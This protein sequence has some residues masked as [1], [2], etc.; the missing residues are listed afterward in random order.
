MNVADELA[1]RNLI[2]RIAWETDTWKSVEV[3]LINCTEDF[4]WQW[5]DVIYRG[6]EGMARR[7]REVLE[8]GICGPGVPARHCIA[9]ME[10]IADP[11]D[12]DTARVRSMAL[13]LRVKDG[14]PSAAL[15][16]DYDDTVRR[17]DGKWLIAKRVVGMI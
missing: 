9:S 14:Q 5:G 10:V 2:A 15:Y 16:G 8:Q 1:I 6:H 3:Y 13:M 11:N 4:S 7:M 17:V 12:P